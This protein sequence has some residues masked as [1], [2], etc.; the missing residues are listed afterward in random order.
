MNDSD[1]RDVI[2]GDV[3][4]SLASVLDRKWIV[5]GDELIAV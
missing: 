1:E 4:Q 5:Q 3:E 2:Q